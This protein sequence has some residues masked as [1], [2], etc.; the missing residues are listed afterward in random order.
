MTA[1]GYIED[2]Q[3]RQA[4]HFGGPTPRFTGYMF[5]EYSIPPAETAAPATA[6]TDALHAM[7]VKRA[8]QLKGCAE[9]SLEEAELKTITEAV[10]AYEAVRWPDGKVPGGKG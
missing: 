3:H 1:A 2:E 10:E 8:N 9:G 7:L 4:A 6:A 5:H